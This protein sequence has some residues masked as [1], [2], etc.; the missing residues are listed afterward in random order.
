MVQIST[1]LRLKVDW[2]AK[3]TRLIL[4]LR[5]NHSVEV[6]AEA[7]FARLGSPAG[8]RSSH[9]RFPGPN[10]NL[11]GSGWLGPNTLAEVGWVQIHSAEVGW[12]FKSTRWRLALALLV[13]HSAINWA[14]H[15]FYSGQLALQKRTE[16]VRRVSELY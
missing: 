16:R 2:R 3:F 15:C 1:R 13:N 9:L 14:K 4:V 5:A 6:L 12:V 8:F 11:L 10:L 7:K